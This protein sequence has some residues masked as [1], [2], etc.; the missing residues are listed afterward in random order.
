M[1]R[2][3]TPEELEQTA[4]ASLE[5]LYA[6]GSRLEDAG[7]N[8]SPAFAAILAGRAVADSIR[9]LTAELAAAF[10]DDGTLAGELVELRDEVERLRKAFDRA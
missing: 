5:A 8:G 4:H 2:E 7:D 9:E 6:F 10:G 1:A 3:H